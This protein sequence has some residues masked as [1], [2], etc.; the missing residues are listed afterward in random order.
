MRQKQGN[1]SKRRNPLVAE[2]LRRVHLVEAW[3]RGVPLILEK[4]PGVE[5]KEIAKIFITS[6]VR[7]SFQESPEQPAFGTSDKT[8]DKTL[9]AIE[10]DIIEIIEADPLVTQKEIAGQLN[11]SYAG[12]RYHT[13]KLKVNGILQRIGGKKAGRWVVTL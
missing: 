12:I 3:G 2:L 13:D 8:S 1:V 7:P 6:F 11:L 9:S 5:F 4:E 10:K